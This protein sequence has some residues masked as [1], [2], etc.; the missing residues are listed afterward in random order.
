LVGTGVAAGVGVE[1]LAGAGA[2]A[3]AD[4]AAVLTGAGAGAAV[5]VAGVAGFFVVVCV[6]AAPGRIKQTVAV[7]TIRFMRFT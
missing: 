5:V 2:D 4:V 3:G 6:N 7:R 1:A